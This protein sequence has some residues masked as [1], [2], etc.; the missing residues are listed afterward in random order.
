VRLRDDAPRGVLP[1]VAQLEMA[2]A[3]L[4]HA[5]EPARRTGS[6]ELRD[7][8]WLQPVLADQ[9]V[10]L[11]IVLFEGDG[12]AIEY[13][14]QSGADDAVVTHGK[15][16]ALWLRRAAPARVDLAALEAQ[17][18]RGRVEAARVY[19]MFASRGFD[20]GPAHRAVVTL[21]L[22]EGQLLARLRLP[23]EVEATER[24]YWLHPSLMDGALQAAACFGADLE[25]ATAAPQVPFALASLRVAARCTREMLAWVRPSAV[26][27]SDR[28]ATLDIDL[29]DTHGQV[30]MQ[31]RGYATR[32][33]SGV[34]D[35]RPH[36]HAAGA[37]AV[38][39]DSAFYRDLLA[40]IASRDVSVDEAVELG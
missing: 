12:D 15:G 10:Q 20:Y 11:S 22:G 24:D 3:A 18:T 13:E 9:H 17:M 23:A 38:E 4:E 29:L 25:Q 19:A 14:I 40:N 37:A 33:L 34:R 6:L 30:C 39:F 28:S 36:R 35:G 8:V 1:G 16:Q 7:H 32:E 21:A 2:R 27:A 26:A 5:S 31:L